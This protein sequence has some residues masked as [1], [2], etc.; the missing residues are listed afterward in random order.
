LTAPVVKGDIDI[1]EAEVRLVN[2]LPPSIVDLGDVRTT[3]DPPLDKSDDADDSA[4]AELDIAINAPG[5]I[6]IRGR[7]LDSEWATSL[8]VKGAAAS[9]RIS[10]RFYALRGRLDFLGKPFDLDTGEITF[11]GEK[12]INPQLDLQLV[13]ETSDMRGSIILA[14]RAQSPELRFASSPSLPEDEILPRL[15]FGRSKQ[16]LSAA[17]ALQLA[18]GIATL[19][20]GGAGPLDTVRAALGFDALRIE[21]EE[22]GSSSVAVGRYV[23]EG[24]YIGAKQAL[25][26]QGGAVV[27]E[28]DVTDNITADVEVGQGGSATSAGVNYKF[29]F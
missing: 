25:D 16:S 1:L 5:K 3:N 15:V 23:R 9:P 14:G 24:V 10:G 4:G 29:D 20:G 19:T 26:G 13:R 17:E 27:I 21:S 22:D 11:R 28:L 7:G 18:S 2:D 6:Y 12:K 8:K